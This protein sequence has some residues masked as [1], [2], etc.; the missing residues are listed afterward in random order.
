MTTALFWV[1]VWAAASA[2]VGVVMVAAVATPVDW[3]LALFADIAFWPID[4]APAI[5]TPDARLFAVIA[6][7]L[8]AGFCATVGLTLDHAMRSGDVALVRTATVGLLVW[9]VLDSTGSL[10]AGAWMNVPLNAAILA[11]FLIPI[12]LW[13]PAK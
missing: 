1:R 6:G 12:G 11:G 9:F 13:K 8:T 10:A 3:P 5:T 4:G 2:A 7:G